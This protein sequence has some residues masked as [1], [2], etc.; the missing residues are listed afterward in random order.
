MRAGAPGGRASRAERPRA[1]PAHNGRG[2]AGDVRARALR[3]EPNRL[4]P[5]VRDENKRRHWRLPD[6]RSR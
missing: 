3:D 1:R 4:G 5:V 2:G 6:G